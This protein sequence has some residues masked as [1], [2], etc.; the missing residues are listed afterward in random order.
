MKILLVTNKAGGVEY[1]RLFV[2]HNDL[3]QKGFEVHKANSLEGATDKEIEGYDIAVFSRSLSGAGMVK[4][5]ADKLRRNGIKIVLDTDDYWHYSKK[6]LYYA[7]HIATKTPEHCIESIIEA[8]YNICTTPILA[9]KIE[10]YNKNVIVIENAIDTTIEQFKPKEIAS[11]KLRFGWFGSACHLEDIELLRESMKVLHKQPALFNKYQMVLGGWVMERNMSWEFEKILT[12]NLELIRGDKN[13]I[14]WLLKPTGEPQQNINK[15]YHRIYGKSADSYAEGLNNI[16]IHL[17][18]LADNDFNSCKSELKVLESGFM[19]K[20]V[21]VSDVYPY[22]FICNDKNSMVV[23]TK[24]DWY[25][26]MR[27]CILN[28]NMVKDYAAQLNE[29]VQRYELQIIN[30]KRIQLYKNIK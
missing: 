6:H 26:W 9:K 16:D 24:M 19:G 1:H 30:E 7:D 22:K 13:F 5:V 8:D 17:I 10:G 25:I 21:I 11:N 23:K 29:D 3:Q 15:R 4:D 28:P 12:N 2:P 20:A 14:E 27:K 18:P